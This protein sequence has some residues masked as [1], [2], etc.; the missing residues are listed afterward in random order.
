MDLTDDLLAELLN[1]LLF[2]LSIAEPFGNGLV[3]FDYDNIFLTLKIT[4]AVML[5]NAEK[6]PGL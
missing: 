2:F 4:F 5:I 1:V 6:N 3:V